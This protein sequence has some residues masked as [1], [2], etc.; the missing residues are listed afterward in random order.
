MQ[1]L[2]NKHSTNSSVEADKLL[3]FIAN[4]MINL[5]KR[6]K[7]Q[8]DPSTL[9]KDAFERYFLQLNLSAAEE[10]TLAQYVSL[11]K[12]IVKLRPTYS[13][14]IFNSMFHQSTRKTVF[15]AEIHERT[16]LAVTSLSS[17]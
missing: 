4:F 5:E 6:F 13:E 8:A 9:L 12:A 1:Q 17:L 16:E 2:F 11:N 14:L 3:T 7:S 15:K 10:L